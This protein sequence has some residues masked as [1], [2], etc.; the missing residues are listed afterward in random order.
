MRFISKS[1]EPDELTAFRKKRGVSYPLFTEN[2]PLYQQVK[3]QLL[4]DQKGLC[5][6]CGI[7][8]AADS[9]HIEHLRISIKTRRLM[10][11]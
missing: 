9:S 7:R 10:M 3:G 6:Y 8:I 11:N 5:C 4:N 2:Q 1:E